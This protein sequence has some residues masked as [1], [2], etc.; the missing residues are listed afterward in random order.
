MKKVL[1]I[2]PLMLLYFSF[3]SIISAK[4]QDSMFYGEAD[5][6]LPSFEITLNCNKY[7]SSIAKYPCFVYNDITYLPL[8]T[9]MCDYMGL[10][11]HNFVNMPTRGTAIVNAFFVGN[12]DIKSTEIPYAE[13]QTNPTSFNVQICKT[14]PKANG[15]SKDELGNLVLYYTIIQSYDHN[16]DKNYPLLYYKDTYYLP[17]IWNYAYEILGWDYSFNHEDGLKIDSRNTYRP[18]LKIHH[19]ESNIVGSINRGMFPYYIYGHDYYI[20]HDI[21]GWKL[22]V[23]DKK[24]GKSQE[25]ILEDYLNDDNLQATFHYNDQS[26]LPVYENGILILEGRVFDKYDSKGIK[27]DALIVIDVYN[28][29]V[30]ITEKK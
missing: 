8:T 15:V 18:E 2:L 12:T 29:I 16:G 3:L 7:N 4:S 9:E 23:Y 19:V 6:S 28:G 21:N 13:V 1:C 17:L 26:K 5:V 24:L 30:T 22:C 11:T 14:T 10:V 25:Y 20:S 27:Y